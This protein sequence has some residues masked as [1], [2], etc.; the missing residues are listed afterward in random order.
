MKVKLTK[1]LIKLSR[2]A[3]WCSLFFTFF[4][5]QQLT[6][7]Y[8]L[9][10][11]YVRGGITTTDP[12]GVSFGDLG[13]VLNRVDCFREIGWKIYGSTGD[14]GW[15]IYGSN[16]VRFINFLGLDETNTKTIGWMFIFVFSVALAS[17]FSSIEINSVYFFVFAAVSV[18]SPPIM[19]LLKLGNFDILI[20]VLLSLFAFLLGSKRL[21][22]AIGALIAASLI[23]FYPAPLL[24]WMTIIQK[25]TSMKVAMAGIFSVVAMQVFVDLNKIESSF[26]Q[27][28]YS[29]FGN[30]IFGS[31]FRYF[32]SYT[33]G[34]IKDLLGL[35]MMGCAIWVT[36]FLSRNGFLVLPD[37]RI[38]T[39]PGNARDAYFSVF[40]LTFLI[41]YFAGLSYDHRLVYLI[42]SALIYISRI[43]N[44]R[45]S[46]TTLAALLIAATWLSVSTFFPVGDLTAG[47]QPIG[48][49][50]ILGFSAIFVRGLYLEIKSYSL[51]INLR[52][53]R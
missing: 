31:Y 1:S 23:K 10:I 11:T 36:Q 45:R 47:F 26:P 34:F 42:M 30:P 41:V 51:P 2:M 12:G 20:F 27:P 29:A 39:K 32:N 46:F 17:I 4:A 16:L 3:R 53:Q 52:F 8:L 14:C 37:T 44:H 43:H 6:D 22:P 18:M 50:A 9:R 33:P 35:V 25:K 38:L 48:D 21:Y 19:L 40:S 13:F 15:Y 28:T 7:W 49:L 24:I 5:S